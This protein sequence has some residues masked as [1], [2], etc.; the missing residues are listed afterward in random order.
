MSSRLKK[1]RFC[2]VGI[3]LRFEHF[4][5]DH[6]HQGFPLVCVHKLLSNLLCNFDL[7]LDG[8]SPKV[9]RSDNLWVVTQLLVSGRFLFEHVQSGPR[10]LSSV[11]GLNQGCLI[12]DPSSGTVDNAD[13]F[14]ALCEGLLAEETSGGRKEGSVDCEEVSLGPDVIQLKELNI[15]LFG[16]F[17]RY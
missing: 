10:Y 9:G 14:L 3:S 5:V 2:N 17:S 12:Y 15:E 7:G 4:R 8:A 1:D 11:D 16:H 6:A 13:A